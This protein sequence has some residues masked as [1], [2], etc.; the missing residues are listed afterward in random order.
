MV[1]VTKAQIFNTLSHIDVSRFVDKIENSGKRRDGTPYSYELSYLSWS[2][3]ESIVSRLFPDWSHKFTHFYPERK[4]KNADGSESIWV[5][6]NPQDY[7]IDSTGCRVECTVTICGNEYHGDLYVMDNRNNAIRDPKQI[8]QANINKTKM[9][10]I[11]KVLAQAGLGASLYI[12]GSD[13]APIAQMLTQAGITQDKVI[14]QRDQAQLMRDRQRFNQIVN[15]V[16]E[17]DKDAKQQLITQVTAKVKE[18][19]KQQ[20]HP[21]AMAMLT[22]LERGQWYLKGLNQVLL[23]Q[24]K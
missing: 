12:K 19:L 21:V 17:G 22:E 9:R 20:E 8:D 6:K 4:I 10:C 11:V 5:S 24:G 18:M 7:L 2:A 15:T 13:D 14:A 1:E 16:T 23:E 3:A